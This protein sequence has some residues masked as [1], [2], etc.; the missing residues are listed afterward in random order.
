MMRRLKKIQSILIVLLIPLV[1]LS[2]TPMIFGAQ[3]IVVKPYDKTWVLVQKTAFDYF[4]NQFNE[5]KIKYERLV[6]V[7]ESERKDW[8]MER[9]ILKDALDLANKKNE[10]YEQEVLRLNSAINSIVSKGKVKDAVLIAS[11]LGNII[12]AFR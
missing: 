4:M 9:S 10:I 3:E 12:N 6:E 5:Y 7:R 11:L 2:S 1:I 8:L